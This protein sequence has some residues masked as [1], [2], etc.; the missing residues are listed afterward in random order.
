MACAAHPV[1]SLWKP[2]ISFRT[3]LGELASP[4]R[5]WKEGATGKPMVRAAHPVN[6]LWKP[7]ISFRT[8]LGELANPKRYWKGNRG[9]TG[10]PM[11]RAAHPVNA[12]PVIRWKHGIIGS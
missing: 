1:N 4:K 11:F 10:K 5:Y 3:Q 7:Q 8:Q 6:S 12:A 9:A 2:Q